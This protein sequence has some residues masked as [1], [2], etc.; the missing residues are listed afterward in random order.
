LI[1]EV[2]SFAV[3]SIGIACTALGIS[4]FLVPGRIAAGG[5]TGLATVIHYWSGWPVGTIALILNIPLFLFGF[6]LIGNRFGIKTLYATIV[7]S[8]FIDLFANLPSVTHDLLLS[9][10]AGGALN[11]IGLGLVFREGATTGGT[12]LAARIVHR[13][14]QYITIAQVL[15]VI[16]ILVVITAAFSFKSYEA[17]LYA[18]VTLVITTKVI[19][20][21]TVGINYSKAAY[22][23][24]SDPD[25]A[26]SRIMK[27]LDRGATML[28]GKGMYTGSERNVLVCVLRAREIARLKYIVKEIDPSAFIFISD[29]REVFGEGFQPHDN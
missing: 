15:M 25:L 6:R 24:C 10:F 18:V 13:R 17:A 11:G 28:Y 19:D 20:S 3:I 29:A 1:K 27:E 2:K 5:V 4:V 9:S 22:I 12:D 14:I 23:I 7:L 16:D 26:A 21:V 8:L